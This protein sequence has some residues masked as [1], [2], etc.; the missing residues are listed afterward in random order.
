MKKGGRKILKVL[1]AITIVCTMVSTLTIQAITASKIPLF[2]AN[3]KNHRV[4]IIKAET[5]ENIRTSS[6]PPPSSSSPRS[7][8]TGA[9]S[10]LSADFG[11]D[12]SPFK[13]YNLS[14][15]GN[16]SWNAGGWV[17]WVAAANPYYQTEK[18]FLNATVVATSID[19]ACAHLYC[20]F[21]YWGNGGTFVLEVYNK[22][23]GKT[24][25]G[26][27]IGGV[28]T[29]ASVPIPSGYA[30]TEFTLSFNV[31]GA[32]ARDFS[33]DNVTVFATYDTDLYIRGLYGIYID[34]ATGKAEQYEIVNGSR[35]QKRPTY[36]MVNVTNLGETAIAR[37]DFHL[38]I[39]KEI[40]LPLK[41][42]KCWD[43]EECFLVSWEA[44]DWNKD[45]STWYYTE[46]RNHSPTHSFHS[47]EDY[48]ATY[49][50]NAHD[51]L[52]LK[53]GF[54]IPDTI[55]VGNL[56]YPVVHAYLSFW[57]W[58]KGEVTNDGEPFGT[59]VDYGQV[60]IDNA[61]TSKPV[62]GKIYDTYGKWEWYD[63]YEPTDE[64]DTDGRKP[65]SLDAWIGQKIRINFTWFAD[66][67]LN[68]E[69]WYI[70]DVC[71][72]LSL[73]SA[74]PLVFQGYAYADIPDKKNVSVIFPIEYE[75][76]DG[77]YYI[78]VYSDYVDCNLD[79]H[80]LGHGY[81][82]EINYSVWFGDVCDAEILSID[83]E[84]SVETNHTCG[85]ADP[86][87]VPIR[88]EV[89]NN[90]TLGPEEIGS[91]PVRIQIFHKI[92]ETL[93]KDDFEDADISDWVLAYTDFDKTGPYFPEHVTDFDANT[94]KYSLAFFTEG[95]NTN[96]Y[97]LNKMNQGIFSPVFDA[98]PDYALHTWFDFAAKWNMNN[99]NIPQQAS[100]GYFNYSSPWVQPNQSYW[101]EHLYWTYGKKVPFSIY[102]IGYFGVG[103][104]WAPGIL[105]PSTEALLFRY[106]TGDKGWII[107]DNSSNIFWDKYNNPSNYFNPF[108]QQWTYPGGEADT[109]S[110][111]DY[112][113]H[114]FHIDLTDTIEHYRELGY[115]TEEMQV[116]WLMST[117]SWGNDNWGSSWTGLMV[118]DINVY[119]EY[120]GAKVWEETKEI[121]L[122]PCETGVIWF[123]WTATDFCDYIIIA[124]I[125][126]ECDMDPTNNEM[127]AQTRIYTT[128]YEDDYENVSCDD[129]TYGQ[130]DHWHI[131]EECSVCPTPHNHTWWNGVESH[132]GYISNT[133]EVLIVNAT[134]NGSGGDYMEIDFDHKYSLENNT[135]YG[136]I[137]ISN[138]SGLTWFT[139]D[140]WIFTGHNPS[141]PHFDNASLT[142]TPGIKLWN[143]DTKQS[144]VVS[145]SFFTDSM[146]V[147]FRMFS[148]ATI[149]WKGWFI[150][151]V[152]I[153]IEN[154]TGKHWRVFFDD[155]E[156]VTWSEK[157]GWLHMAMYYGCHWHEESKFGNGPTK[158]WFWNGENRSFMPNSGYYY[159]DV[160][161]KL[162]FEY[163]LTHAYEAILSFDYNYSFNYSLYKGKYDHGVVEISTDGG[164]TWEIL[165]IYG[166]TYGDG[167]NT[168][169]AWVKRI[170]D[171]S[172]YAGR[173]VPVLIRFH[174][175]D[176]SDG[177][178]D[179][180][181]LVDNVT[182]TGKVDYVAPNITAT[183]DP[184]AP[185]GNFGWYR[186][187]VTVTITA[188]DNVKV[189]A[190]YYRID[191][192]SWNIYT[193]PIT[194]DTDGEHIVEYYAV[195]GV[196]NPSATGSISF[197]IDRTAPIA[198][199]TYPEAGYIYL[200]GR[201]LFKSLFGRTIV[202]GGMT[203]Q[204]S[205]SDATSGIY[206]V[207][208]EINGMVYE[209]ATPPYEIW[210]HKFDLL[211]HKYMLTIAAYDIAGNKAADAT[212]QFIHWL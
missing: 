67:Y 26:T 113:M 125:Q 30:G 184:M 103:D 5:P 84:P 159:Y 193:S 143:W 168:S 185:D 102:E 119:Y 142:I 109:K 89:H 196:G 70:D 212:M 166:G 76:E 153:S 32:R 62:T 16:W 116:G 34:P 170:I 95:P 7:P 121:K 126:L 80:G 33:I 27:F 132:K 44:R 18:D 123:N 6:S 101:Y 40:P 50:Y 201:Q 152:N 75:F 164:E 9:D 52:I 45:G 97:Y 127:N 25:L 138:D 191:N 104:A 169:G 85:T 55:K 88:V 31:S 165:K 4:S 53:E 100:L 37:A 99:T 204:A 175:T 176:N 122:K 106:P 186:S 117:T 36:I 22:T 211:P 66:N 35:H 28:K 79:N 181:W 64:R 202:I 72:V 156:N 195:D 21:Y 188:E 179:Y 182:I 200:F 68:Y 131:I 19:G 59:P 208:F 58:C 60:Y 82:D 98:P 69:G 105:D 130:P 147:R 129:N 61:T 54:T 74:E 189:T 14:G 73:K 134:F 194:I 197:K 128:I 93:F 150:D 114:L 91:I 198:S 2:A 167:L 110:N 178:M 157:Y 136:F 192:G 11:A 65:I 162:V 207:T 108:K 20:E 23:V 133:D 112:G 3:Q 1:I 154:L 160:D 12:L 187:S 141:W 145:P 63:P 71:I 118:D 41:D 8:P 57:H 24:I 49:E 149:E 158:E 183:L 199:I 39:Y 111:A 155:M 43:M 124:T 210:W 163:D 115:L 38:Q 29:L 148:N 180:G 86:V 209:K 177:Y 172:G 146:H 173:D 81:A 42:Y 151:N 190:I 96:K 203:F 56:T 144:I 206:Y 17:D 171:I 120:V 205:A 94:G 47:Q 15:Y 174:F 78:Q 13:A 161:E 87:K 139:N 135:D 48:L 92:K 107:T 137:E 51:S 46:K 90:G 77:Y 10:L 140:S 83:V